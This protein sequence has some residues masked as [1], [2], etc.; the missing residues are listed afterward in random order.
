LPQNANARLT[1]IMK[2]A[3]LDELKD[4]SPKIE[5]NLSIPVS[6]ELKTRYFAMRDELRKRNVKTLNALA[7]ERLTELL[8]ELKNV[9]E[10]SA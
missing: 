5:E 7:R 4:T 2:I 3:S 6:K 1:L 9:L 8:D 10:T